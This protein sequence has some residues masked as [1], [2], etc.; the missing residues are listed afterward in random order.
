MQDSIQKA[1]TK[2]NG[3]AKEAIALHQ[4]YE[5]ARNIAA[6]HLDKYDAA[7]EDSDRKEAIKWFG[8]A[9][10]ATSRLM[11]IKQNIA[12]EASVLSQVYELQ[13]SA[14]ETNSL[15][16]THSLKAD[17]EYYA[18]MSQKAKNERDEY[19]AYKKQALAS[20]KELRIKKTAAP[21]IPG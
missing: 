17:V 16:E 6:R 14:N 2:I 12:W 8:E 5:F 4:Q 7:G 1:K 13:Q 18:N 11:A 9:W 15:D 10:K 3:W 21:A 19:L 20:I